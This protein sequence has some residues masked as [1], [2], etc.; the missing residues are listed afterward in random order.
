MTLLMAVFVYAFVRNRPSEMGLPPLN[1]DRGEVRKGP[2]LMS[3]MKMVLS[4]G[5]FWPLAVWAFCIIGISFAIGGL[6]GGPYLMQIYGYSK[7]TAGGVLSTF[8]LAL[9]F[10]S[11][12]LGWFA[13]RFGRKSVLVGC[14]VIFLAVSGIMSAYVDAMTLPALY[15][16][17]FSLFVSGG[18]VGPIMAAVAKELFPVSISGTAVGAINLFPFAGAAF[19]QILIGAVLTAR[20]LDQG[21]YTADGFRYMFL[22]CLAGAVL[23]L[24]AALIMKE[25]L[26]EIEN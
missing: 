19:F 18:A 9:I 10:G 23:S 3:G 14:S 2:G 8:A 22:I 13:N 6:W 12:V 21:Q 24:A 15:V 26:G 5:R 11:P 25:T 17:F 4:S 16:L 7:T 1:P 20:S